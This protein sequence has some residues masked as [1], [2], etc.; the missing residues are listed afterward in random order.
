MTSLTRR[1]DH[2][3]H[4]TMPNAGPQTAIGLKAL[5]ASS[6]DASSARRKTNTKHDLLLFV[7]AFM[8]TKCYL[9]VRQ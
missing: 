1:H 2:R 3:H 7:L 6:D 9:S 8:I 5:E 4:F